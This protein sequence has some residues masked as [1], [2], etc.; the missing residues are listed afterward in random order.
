[1][2]KKLILRKEDITPSTNEFEVIGVFNPTV[3][4]V[5][6]E[7]VMIARVAERPIQSDEF[8]YLVPILNDENRI[9]IHQIPKNSDLYDY[10]DIRVIKNHSRN[11]LTSMSH[12]RVGRSKDGINFTFNK[13]ILPTCIYEEYGMEDPRITKIDDTYYITYSAISSLGINS[14]L[15]ETKDFVN[16][17]KL[18]L[19]FH[20]DNKDVVLFPRKVNGKYYALHRP[21]IS[22]FGSLDIWTAE[23]DNLLYWGNHKVLLR[24]KDFGYNR[25]GAGAVPFETEYGFIEIFHFADD[26]NNYF[27]GAMLLDKNDPSKMIKFIKKPLVKPTEKYEINGFMPNVVFTCGLIQYEN[28][29]D[30]YYGVCDENIAVA[31]ITLDELYSFL[32][33]K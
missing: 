3:I 13:F 7:V 26:D 17:N 20:S 9:V 1:M 25:L 4:K 32:E 30:V 6:D 31:N 8:N 16:F 19:I 23:S 28:S 27:L 5:D 12:F 33:V 11:Y 29:I 15:M 14:M 10:S 2:N 22:N 18:G 24:T 21:S